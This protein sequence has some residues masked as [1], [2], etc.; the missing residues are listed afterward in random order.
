MSAFMFRRAMVGRKPGDRPPSRRYDC[1]RRQATGCLRCR[2]RST[3]PE[4]D[5]TLTRSMSGKQDTVDSLLVLVL[6]FF[7]FFFDLARQVNR[8]GASGGF[9][10]LARLSLAAHAVQTGRP[11]LAGGACVGQGWYAAIRVLRLR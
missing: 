8:E 11:G 3:S 4:P 2:H 5:S 9:G 7:I 1:V 6:A 10:R